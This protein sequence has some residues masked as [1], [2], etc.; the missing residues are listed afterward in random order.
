MALW[1]NRSGGH[2]DHEAKFP[3]GNAARGGGLNCTRLLSME[4]SQGHAQ[5]WRAGT[6]AVTSAEARA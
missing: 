1:L 3:G 6:K 4:A 2:G 5:L